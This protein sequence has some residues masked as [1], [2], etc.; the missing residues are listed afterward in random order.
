MTASKKRVRTA[1]GRNRIRRLVRESF[2]HAVQRLPA[3][4]IVVVVRDGARDAENPRIV[5][6]LDAHWQ[7]LGRN[8]ARG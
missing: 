2:R 4:D 6:S 8:A 3:L 5:A 7:R 1:V